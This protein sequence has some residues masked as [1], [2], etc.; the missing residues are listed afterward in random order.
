MDFDLSPE[1]TALRDRVRDFIRRE[2][3]PLEPRED[4]HDGLPPDLL[5]DVRRKA[6]AAG[7]WAPQL[8]RDY[9]GLGLETVALCVLFEEAGASPPAPPALHCPPPPRGNLPLLPPPP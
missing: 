4:E 8:P 5:A 7:V 2:V 6:R 9:G 3:L 1:V